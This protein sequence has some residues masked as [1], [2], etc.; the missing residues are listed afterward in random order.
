MKV[1][2]TIITWLFIVVFI[3]GVF[4]CYIN[5]AKCLYYKAY[6]GEV[7]GDPI[8][9]GKPPKANDVLVDIAERTGC[10]YNVVF[11]DMEDGGYTR[12]L[13]GTIHLKQGLDT[14]SLVWCYTHEIMHHKCF[15]KNDLYVQV[16]TFKFLYECGDVYYKYVAELILSNMDKMSDQYNAQYYIYAYLEGRDENI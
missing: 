3:G 11:E 8:Y 14:A 16:E 9:V 2:N 1:Y 15:T 12:L 4:L 7:I 13:S 10:R 6:D 5:F